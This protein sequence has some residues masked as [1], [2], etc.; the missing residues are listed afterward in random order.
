MSGERGPSSAE[1]EPLGIFRA[2]K[3]IGQ[4]VLRMI[5]LGK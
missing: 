1:H 2:A 5:G 4:S 3:M